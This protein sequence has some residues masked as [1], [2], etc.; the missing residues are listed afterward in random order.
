[1]KVYEQN[2]PSAINNLKTS[3]SELIFV[4]KKKPNKT[5]QKIKRTKT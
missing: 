2:R 4:K 1:M 5:E 3:N